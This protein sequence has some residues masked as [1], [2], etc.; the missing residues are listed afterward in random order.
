[1]KHTGKFLIVVMTVASATSFAAGSACQQKAIEVAR[2]IS[3]AKGLELATI[4]KVNSDRESNGLESWLV[5]SQSTEENANFA[6]RVVLEK[7]GEC[8]FRGATFVIDG[9][10]DEDVINQLSGK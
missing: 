5:T 7:F 10:S 8:Y 3:G 1:M 9:K 2:S 4:E 6:V